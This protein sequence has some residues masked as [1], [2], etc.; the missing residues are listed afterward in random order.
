MATVALSALCLGYHWLKRLPL[1]KTPL[2]GLA[3]VW[4]CITLPYP[5]SR[6]SPT[7]ALSL[8]LLFAAGAVLC[9]L[10]D[11]E[12]DRSH[13]TRTLPVLLGTRPACAIATGLAITGMVL[14]GYPKELIPT[15]LLLA[16]LA[17]FPKL[18]TKPAVGPML[19]DA[20]YL[21]PG[22]ITLWY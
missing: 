8:F 13:G 11:A 7:F 3:W 21:L 20:V 12:A 10:K 14:P 9:D 16:L 2:I 15:A 22:L 4:A 19:V 17:Q 6:V 18:L 1:L 5:D